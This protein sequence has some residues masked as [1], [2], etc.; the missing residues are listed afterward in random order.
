M[1]SGEVRAT[2]FLST[3]GTFL[4]SWHPSCHALPAA[5][6]IRASGSAPLPAPAEAMCIWFTDALTCVC[7]LPI[8]RFSNRLE[9][10]LRPGSRQ[11]SLASQPRALLLECVLS[12]AT[13]CMGGAWVA[14][15]PPVTYGA[16][17][18][19]AS[20]YDFTGTSIS[21]ACALTCI[22]CTQDAHA[23]QLLTQKISLNNGNAPTHAPANRPLHLSSREY[24]DSTAAFFPLLLICRVT[25][26]PRRSTSWTTPTK[27]RCAVWR[28][29]RAQWEQRAKHGS[30]QAGPAAASRHCPHVPACLLH[31]LPCKPAAQVQLRT[32]AVLTPRPSTA[33]CSD[34]ALA[35][36]PSHMYTGL[37]GQGRHSVGQ[38]LCF[39]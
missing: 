23:V 39:G 18:Q 7:A 31:L 12:Y 9:A 16:L 4:V 2:D 5:P 32:R 14:L 36:P 6:P 25:Y 30:M 22:C 21:A 8:C 17:A 15:G 34:A 37:T 38:K 10:R 1:A 26:L 20:G 28:G 3:D 33:A 13:L 19:E 35:V 24:H 29:S 11:M 27:S